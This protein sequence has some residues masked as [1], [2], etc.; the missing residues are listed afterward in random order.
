MCPQKGWS[1]SSSSCMK[2]SGK[3]PTEKPTNGRPQKRLWP[4]STST[5]KVR[6]SSSSSNEDLTSSDV[7][8]RTMRS[9]PC[10]KNTIS[11]TLVQLSMSNFRRRSWTSTS[12]DS[13][14]SPTSSLKLWGRTTSPSRNDWELWLYFQS[15]IYW[16][17]INDNFNRNLTKQEV[18]TVSYQI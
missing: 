2:R 16:R 4:I 8:L 13:H 7:C 18:Q 6:L 9:E 5:I 1:K 14:P 17:F 12:A 15:M 10:S 11:I 3:S